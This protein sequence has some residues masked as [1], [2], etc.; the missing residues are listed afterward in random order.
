MTQVKQLATQQWASRPADERF[1]SLPEML[2]KLTHDRNRSDEYRVNVRDVT[3]A[4][5]G[6]NDITVSLDGGKNLFQPTHWSFGQLTSLGKSPGDYLRELGRRGASELV[7]D[8]LN[9]GLRFM[10]DRDEIGALGMQRDGSPIGELQATTG[11]DYGR[12]WNHQIVSA[13][14]ERFGDGVTGDFKV[15]GEFG[16]DVAITRNNTTLYASDRD[17]FVFL[18][19]ERNRI[20]I[21]NRRHGKAG[22]LARGFF[23][24]NSQVGSKKLGLATFLFD[25]ICANRTVWGGEQYA[26][27]EIRHSSGAPERWL[28]E[29]QPALLTYA[30]DTSSNI[31]EAVKAAQAAKI[32]DDVA[33]FM[34][35]RFGKNTAAT[36]RSMHEVEEERPIETLWDASVAATAFA[37][38]IEHQDK[39]VAVER[40]AGDLIKLAA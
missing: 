6:P 26:E 3:L 16:K 23:V 9:F 7:A 39:R 27:I 12:V 21:P 15:P 19:D 14:I 25:F 5:N 17:M 37:R 24:W 2:A 1:V 31:V 8:N 28:Q 34:A 20:E 40:Q 18:A 35:K 30:N 36:M 22:S 10:R 33:E 13:L 38:T 11:P 4:P 29:M 32:E